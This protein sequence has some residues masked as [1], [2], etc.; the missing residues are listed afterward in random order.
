M[1]T[2]LPVDYR[3]F[4]AQTPFL[5]E[6]HESP[7]PAEA[8]WDDLN[9]LRTSPHALCN[10]IQKPL[11]ASTAITSSCATSSPA[12]PG[13]LRTLARDLSTE[14]RR[15]HHREP[16]H[17]AAGEHRAPPRPPPGDVH[18]GE[19]HGPRSLDGDLSGRG[20]EVPDSCVGSHPFGLFPG[21]IKDF[22]LIYQSKMQTRII[23][24]AKET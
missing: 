2:R 1:L 12:G 3:T 4:G 5:L 6:H 19:H 11:N 20:W 10:P 21:N 24:Y 23:T 7:L 15:R 22:S 17:G 16:R 9:D 8:S 18:R 14:S 13:W